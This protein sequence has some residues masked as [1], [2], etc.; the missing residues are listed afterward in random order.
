MLNLLRIS[1]ATQTLEC[2]TADPQICS[3][4]EPAE[5]ERHAADAVSC[6]PSYSISTAT[7]GLGE[8][9]GSWQTPRG[10]HYI[11]ACIGRDLPSRAV[12]AGRRWTG[13]I[14]DTDLAQRYPQRDWIL[15]RILW[16]CGLEPGVNRGD[17][18]DTQRRYIYIHGTADEHLLGT[19]A[20]HGCI[21][22]AS[23]DVTA[24]YERVQ[25]GC[26]VIIR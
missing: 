3:A 1:A 8:C 2:L 20:S 23:D 5:L 25:P 12:L 15:T 21:R 24:L 10:W 17:G 19:A 11:R 4:C 16:L 26:R 6:G 7:A 22:M 13:E 9:N 14:F 18:V